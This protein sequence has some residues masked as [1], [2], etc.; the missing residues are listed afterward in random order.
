VACTGG[1]W[2]GAFLT[3]P[4]IAGPFVSD[5]PRR[6]GCSPPRS[7]R[8][9]PKATIT[10]RLSP[11]AATNSRAE[12]GV[13]LAG[14]RSSSLQSWATRTPALQ[15]TVP[16][17]CR[18]SFSSSM[19]PA[20][21]PPTS[22]QTDASHPGRSSMTPN[23]TPRPASWPRGTR[24]QPRGLHLG[25]RDRHVRQF[26]QGRKVA[27]L[28]GGDLQYTLERSEAGRARCPTTRWS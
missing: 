16:A 15:P 14:V 5:N 22:R 19:N 23:K 26:A 21:K 20:A 7:C 18:G 10:V 12:W 17:Q 1:P 2:C 13:P 9:G 27:S 3:P 28:T 6:H 11:C 8:V 4:G 24:V 25:S